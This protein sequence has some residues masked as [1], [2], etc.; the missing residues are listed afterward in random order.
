MGETAVLC[1]SGTSDRLMLYQLVMDVDIKQMK[2]STLRINQ[3]QN[4]P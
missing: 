2:P 1:Q 3:T 4:K